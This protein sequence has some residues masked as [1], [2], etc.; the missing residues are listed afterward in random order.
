MSSPGSSYEWYKNQ[1]QII[2]FRLENIYIYSLY[3]RCWE[4]FFFCPFCIGSWYTQ[5]NCLPVYGSYVQP[6]KLIFLSLLLFH[7]LLFLCTSSWH[8]SKNFYCLSLWLNKCP[9]FYKFSDNYIHFPI[10]QCI[11]IFCSFFKTIF[12]L[13]FFL[14]NKLRQFK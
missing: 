1:G 14:L 4:S 10:T 7:F 6:I 9:F 8:C 5:F 13:F 12:I 2:I 3:N 11:L